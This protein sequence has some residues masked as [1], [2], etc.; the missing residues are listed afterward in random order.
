MRPSRAK[1][2]FSVSVGAVLQVGLE[3]VLSSWSAAGMWRVRDFAGLGRDD[4]FSG[5]RYALS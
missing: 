5:L 1:Q 2:L 4:L 3:G